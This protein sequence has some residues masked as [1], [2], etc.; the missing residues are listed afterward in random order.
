MRQINK[1]ITLTMESSFFYLHNERP[2]GD[3]P[4]EAPCCFGCLLRY[5]I[6]F[7]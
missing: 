2:P 5:G 7:L 4:V 3:H 1:D 6:L